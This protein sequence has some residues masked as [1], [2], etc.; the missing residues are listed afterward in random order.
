V[1][2]GDTSTAPA[3]LFRD[4]IHD[5]ATDPVVV[6]HRAR[7]EWWMFY[8]AR[9]ATAP[10]PG[11]AWVHGSDVGV[12]V[13][14]D[15]G[16]NWLYRGTVQGLETGPGRDTFW[17]PEVLWA[18]GR[19]HMFVTHIRGVPDRWEGH[20]RTILH[21]VSD[22]LVGWEPRGACEVG[23]PRAI[24]AAVHPLPAG[25]YRMWF[26]D[27]EHGSHT[28]CA[29]SADLE[30]WGPAR[31]VITDRE[32]EGPNVF[33]LAGRYWLIVDEWRGLGVYDSD[34][35]DAWH[36]NGLILNAA[37]T[38]PD[39]ADHGWHADV[40]VTSTAARVFYFTH[41]ERSSLPPD[42]EESYRHRRSSIQ[43]AGLRVVDGRLVC[44]RDEEVAVPVLS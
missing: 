42:G 13:S 25:G 43:V 36:R 22:D 21:Y 11:V 5:G 41:P 10:G 7:D 2:V 33:A 16:T 8:T 27:E 20:D 23:S 4:P 6:R 14:T 17:A 15:G 3:P 26:K 19:Y 12:A 34:D 1:S 35:L 31:P 44:D 30:T 37:G 29:D 40:V 38:R 28:Y 39:D 18:E 24:D 9:R 32:H